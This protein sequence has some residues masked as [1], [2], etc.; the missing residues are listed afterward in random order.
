[1]TYK[2]SQPWFNNLTFPSLFGNSFSY[3]EILIAS[4]HPPLSQTSHNF[5][6]MEMFT[7]QLSWLGSEDP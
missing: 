7:T 1:M 6:A 5:M 4:A 2:I 3:L